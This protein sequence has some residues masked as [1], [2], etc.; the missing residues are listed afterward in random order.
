MY[1]YV[2]FLPG[3][4]FTFW[5]ILRKRST[6]HTWRNM[7]LDNN[8]SRIPI[9]WG[10]SRRIYKRNKIQWSKWENEPFE[11]SY[12][13]N[14]NIA[15]FNKTRESTACRLSGPHM[16][17][18]KAPC[19]RERIAR[20]H[21]FFIWAGFQLGITYTKWEQSWHCML[22]KTKQPIVTKL[23]IIQLFEGDFN[24]ALKYLL[25]RKLMKY[26]HK[27]YMHDTETFGSRIGKTSPEALQ[28]I[29]LLCNHSRI[30]KKLLLSSSMMPKDAMIESHQTYVQWRHKTK[31]AQ[32]P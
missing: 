10:R 15:T 7:Q 16:S 17:H 14:E 31:A 5:K 2:E 27:N 29:R 18:W 4:Y 25:G 12:G 24:A 30:W 32:S 23:Q 26:M 13:T 21:T 3:V 8:G 9:I 20:V 19:E 22:Q 28:N 1:T 6:K 11:W